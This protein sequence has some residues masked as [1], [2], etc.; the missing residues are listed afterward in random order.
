MNATSPWPRPGTARLLSTALLFAWSSP[1]AASSSYA[2]EPAPWQAE[3]RTEEVTARVTSYVAGTG[4]VI[5][6]GVRDGLK[7]GD[8]VVFT[9]RG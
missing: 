1:A 5:D 9:A 2:A 8:R 3:N 6:R 4:I 7:V